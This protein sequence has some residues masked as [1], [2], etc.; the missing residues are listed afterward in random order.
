MWMNLKKI[1]LTAKQKTT[2]LYDSFIGAVQ[3][4]QTHR[5]REQISGCQV[6]WGW[7]GGGSD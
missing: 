5:D 7:C 2:I 6:T 4:S 1:M 3:N